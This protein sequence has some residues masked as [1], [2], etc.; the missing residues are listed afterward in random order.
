MS[1]A[2]NKA[3]RFYSIRPLTSK[4][5]VEC[6]GVDL[7]E[8]DILKDKRFVEQIKYDLVKH[9]AVLFRKQQL[10]GQRQVDISNVLGT[11]E[12]TFY[13]HPKSPH[14]DIFRVSNDEDEGCTHVGRSGW[15]IDGTFQAMPFMYQTM[16]FPSVTKGG[17][18]YFTP[19]KE[20]FEGFSSKDQEYLNRLWMITGRRQ[21][22]VH[23]LVYKHPF[24]SGGNNNDDEATM[25]FHCGR[26]FVQGFYEEKK[27]NRT[28]IDA[29]NWPSAECL[30]NMKFIPA[31]KIQN[32][33]TK[34]IQSR[35]DDI[36]LKMKWEAGDFMI[37][38]NLGLAHYATKGTQCESR[39]VGLRILH[40]TTIVGGP[41][42]VPQ[43][44]DGRRSF[45]LA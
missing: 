38:D 5:G 28:Q 9:R 25:L 27:T 44:V 13:K 11:I 10:S 12:S 4:F 16:Y 29:Q 40:R 19:L 41:E 20:L 31:E 14:P 36:G 2:T 21:A 17:D 35:L 15:H 39:S 33:L 24:R 45:A 6:L 32:L 8:T 30:N 37:S 23:P 7:A 22:P 42:T 1:I 26:S 3:P 34:T 43:K 18:T